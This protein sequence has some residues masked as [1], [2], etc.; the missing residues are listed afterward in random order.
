M[1]VRSPTGFTVYIDKASVVPLEPIITTEPDQAVD[2]QHF[3]V[4][5]NQQLIGDGFQPS[6]ISS[7]SF[8]EIARYH[9]AFDRC[10]T[11]ATGTFHWCCYGW[12]T[13]AS[14]FQYQLREANGVTSGTLSVT[15]SQTSP[16]WRG[17]G[18]ITAYD[19]GTENEW[20]LEAKYLSGTPTVLTCGFGLFTG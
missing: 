8:V 7:A 6:G 16:L 20:I 15:A 18:S 2:D 5:R 17:W 1:A 10:N 14:N 4:L 9:C 13:T 11:G 3:A 19:D 12:A